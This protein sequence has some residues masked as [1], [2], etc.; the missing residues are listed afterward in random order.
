MIQILSFG[1][2]VLF[3][4]L[5]IIVFLIIM[6]SGNGENPL[7]FMHLVLLAPVIGGGIFL[8]RMALWNSFG[9]EIYTFYDEKM[10]YIADYGWFNDSEKSMQLNEIVFLVNLKNQDDG[11][12]SLLFADG[13]DEIQ[14]V[15]KLP[16]DQLYE[17]IETLE[18]NY[19]KYDE[20]I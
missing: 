2:A 1:L 18:S 15:I 14:S 11:K 6:S 7:R 9:K 8:L 10:Q 20:E 3:L 19:S 16:N 13:R 5:P 4:L 12:G 17:L